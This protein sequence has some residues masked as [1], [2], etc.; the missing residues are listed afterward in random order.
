MGHLD[1]GERDEE[2]LALD[3]FQYANQVADRVVDGK[4]LHEAR[5]AARELQAAGLLLR[6]ALGLDQERALP[7]GEALEKDQLDDLARAGLQV[8][9]VLDPDLGLVV[10]PETVPPARPR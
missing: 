9:G 5:I 2:R 10:Y 6:A 4:A 7:V 8:I 1:L 3:H